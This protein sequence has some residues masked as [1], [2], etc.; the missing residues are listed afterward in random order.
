MVL[1]EGEKTKKGGKGGGGV[2]R[3]RLV[4]CRVRD[5]EEEKGGGGGGGGGEKGLLYIRVFR[6]RSY[7][8]I[9]KRRENPI[10]DTHFSKLSSYLALSRCLD[11]EKRLT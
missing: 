11:I 2:E 10:K 9:C 1:F 5:D 3:Q 6:G 7:G 8:G 4:V